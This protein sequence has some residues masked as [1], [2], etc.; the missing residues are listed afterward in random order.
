VIW[1]LLLI[2][3]DLFIFTYI[4]YSKYSILYRQSQ[5]LSL[6]SAKAA[7]AASPITPQIV[8]FEAIP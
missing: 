6:D 7:A 2:V 4:T 1:P 3:L 5:P 8:D